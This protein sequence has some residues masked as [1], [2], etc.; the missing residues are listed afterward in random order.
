MDRCNLPYAA[1]GQRIGLLGGSFDPAHRGH[2]A[3]TMAALKRFGLD[4]VWWLVTPGNP[5]KD[6]GP[7][8]M[9]RRLDQAAQIMQHPRVTITDIERQLG[10]RYTADTL[11]A[12]GQRYPH[13]AFTW[14]MGADNLADFHRWQNWQ[15]IMATVR[16]GVLA[17][18]GDRVAARTSKAAKMFRGWR[19]PS[20]ALASAPAPAWAFENFPMRDVSSSAIRAAGQW[21]T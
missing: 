17:R 4:R 6:R 16:I 20:Q 11:R 19:V 1:L 8:S 5:L 7:A 13:V 15:Y 14:V 9:E 18:P 21:P 10:T 2:V 3:I 12:L